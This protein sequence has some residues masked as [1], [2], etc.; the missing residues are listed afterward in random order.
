MICLT[1]S[2]AYGTVVLMAKHKNPH[3]V[4]LGR[5]GGKARVPKGIAL[6]SK[7]DRVALAKKA[8]AARWRKRG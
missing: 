7:Q 4:A 8:A 1:P 2:S 5:L 3:A 6:L